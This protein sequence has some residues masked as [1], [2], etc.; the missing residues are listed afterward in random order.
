MAKRKSYNPFKMWGSWVGAGI[1]IIRG[2]MAVTSESEFYNLM[3]IFFGNF[4][5]VFPAIIAVFGAI[6]GFLTGWAIH[7]LIRRFK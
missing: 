3:G 2:I 7:A 1:G 6:S 4:R 5:M